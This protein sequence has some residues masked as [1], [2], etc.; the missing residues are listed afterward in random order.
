MSANHQCVYCA[1]C[2]LETYCTTFFI[3]HAA[4]GV[5]W[6]NLWTTGNPRDELT[7]GMIMLML[8]LDFFLYCFLIWYV[9]QVSPGTY[10]VSLP[11]YF[12]FQVSKL[13]LRSYLD[14]LC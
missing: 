7:P 13:F 12:P 2:L 6:N 10:G 9:D 14:I 4:L 1:T 3:L 5:Q 11:W 8:V